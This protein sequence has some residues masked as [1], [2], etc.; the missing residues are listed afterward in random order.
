MGTKCDKDDWCESV[1]TAK[2][3]A[4]VPYCVE[5]EWKKINLQVFVKELRYHKP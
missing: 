5:N 3:C 1:R 4:R 2:K